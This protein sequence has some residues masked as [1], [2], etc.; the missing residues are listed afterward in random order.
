MGSLALELGRDPAPAF[1]F[2]TDSDPDLKGTVHRFYIE[3]GCA[4][5]HETE[6]VL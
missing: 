2:A 1:K 3:G 4:G 5:V 6:Y